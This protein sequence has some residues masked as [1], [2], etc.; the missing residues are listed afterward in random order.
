MKEEILTHYK[1]TTET[2]ALVSL[3]H[4]D[5]RTLAIERKGKYY[6]TQSPT[7]IIHDACIDGGSTYDGRKKVVTAHL[8]F[9][10][11]V[12]I[13]INRF[14]QIYAFPTHSP[15]QFECSWIFYHHIQ[16]LNAHSPKQTM[17]TFKNN[18]EIILPIS[19]VKLEKQYLRTASCILRF[20]QPLHFQ[21][22]YS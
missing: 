14:A 7:D 3:A 2:M 11:K 22:L 18:E 5:Y 9:K 20:A 6:I 4:F 8:N 13:P 21:A 12:P 16:S 10:Y 19:Y 1:V 15:K 17:I